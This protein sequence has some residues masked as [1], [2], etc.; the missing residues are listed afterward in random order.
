M[1]LIVCVLFFFNFS[2]VGKIVVIKDETASG[3]AR[4]M[5]NWGRNEEKKVISMLIISHP[6]P[7]FAA[8]GSALAVLNVTLLCGSQYSIYH[9]LANGSTERQK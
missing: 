4:Q 9:L 5:M 3:T 7:S 8:E 1:C 2:H 6:L